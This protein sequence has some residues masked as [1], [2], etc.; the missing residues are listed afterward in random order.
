MTTPQPTFATP[1][2]AAM[3]GFPPRHCRVLACDV[4]G[5]HAYVLLNTGTDAHPYLYGGLVTREDDGWRDGSSG[6]GGGWTR[7]PGTEDIGV[8]SAWDEAPAG[9][10]AVRLSWNGEVREVPVVGGAYLAT[11]WGVPV[12]LECWPRVIAFRFNGRWI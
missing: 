8:L 1:E 5:Y 9:A 6:N 10:D 11:W 4:E 12:D 2:E 3:N 7:L